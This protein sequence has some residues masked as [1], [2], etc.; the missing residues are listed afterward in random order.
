MDF[1]YRNGN[2]HYS[3]HLIPLT[4]IELLNGDYVPSFVNGSTGKQPTGAFHHIM[5]TERFRLQEQF[6]LLTA[7]KIYGS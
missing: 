6:S 5:T 7:Q 3:D 2:N 4:I 1:D